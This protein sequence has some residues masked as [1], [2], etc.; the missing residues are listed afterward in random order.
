MI[1]LITFGS[2][3]VVAILGTIGTFLFYL[4]YRTFRKAQE[5]ETFSEK[6]PTETAKEIESGQTF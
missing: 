4:V 5:A 1:F 3:V 2:L 6:E